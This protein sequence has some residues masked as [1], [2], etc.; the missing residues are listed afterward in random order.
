LKAK[1]TLNNCA[2]IDLSNLSTTGQGILDAKASTSLDNLTDE[3]EEKVNSAT[4]GKLTG[5]LT[6]QS[7]LQSSL[8]LKSDTSLS[9]LT[10][11]GKAA[12]AHYTMPSDTSVALTAG[13]TGTKYTAPADGWAAISG[14]MTAD[15][16]MTR[17]AVYNRQGTKVTFVVQHHQ[18][19]NGSGIR[20]IVP[21]AANCIFEVS[22]S[23][24][25]LTSVGFV[26]AEGSAPETS[27]S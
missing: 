3:G 5:S 24:V 12:C 25:K 23:N 22:Y 11:D 21:V 6:E 17:V 20:F 14:S 2:D 1:T 4:W 8:E 7:D 16:G 26:Y 19:P 10:S 15:G 27:E 9:N 13:A 18:Y